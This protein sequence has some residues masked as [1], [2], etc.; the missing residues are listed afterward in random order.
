MKRLRFLILLVTKSISRYKYYCLLFILGVVFL[1][2]GWVKV[3]ELLVRPQVFEGMVGTYT[4]NQ[5]PTEVTRLLSQSLITIDK[6]GKPI[7]DIA[8]KW[9]ISAD[10]KTYTL[11]L[12]PNLYWTDGTKLKASDIQLAIPDV[13]VSAPNDTTLV[14]KLSEPFSPTLTLLDKPLLKVNSQTNFLE[15]IGPYEISQIETSQDVFVKRLVLHTVDKNLP[16]VTIRFY[17]NEDVADEALQIG[18]V[19][20]LIGANQLDEFSNQPPYKIIS[21]TDY[22]Q[23]VTIFY[24]TK[25]PTLSDKNLRIALSYAAPIIPHQASASTSLS[26]S[27]WAFNPDIP[28]YLNN[29]A[30]AKAYL[31]KVKTASGSGAIVLT[32]T[33]NL[34]QV[35]QEVVDAWR[36]AGV[37]AKLQV[38]SGIPQNFQAL[39]ITSDIPS[40]PDQYSLWH[41]TQTETNISG[42]SFARADKDLE[43]GRKNLDPKVRLAA[44]LDLQKVLHDD[45]PATFLYFPK[46][47]VIYLNKIN[48][49]LQQLLPL[50]LPYLFD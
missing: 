1:I 36:E 34:R 46:Y 43:D 18:E 3:S 20:S 12:K 4:E 6:S 21:K 38:E 26:P 14:L 41:S 35:G 19:Q 17:P 16:S 33:D 29:S 42:Y 9:E 11:T 37:S 47:N 31:D 32:A 28:A 10:Q 45:A 7:P 44:Y 50:Q 5:L 48:A 40:D 8:S 2:V 24:K 22:Q 13:Q 39:L 49:Q 15:G 23:L 30:E 25:D 27:S